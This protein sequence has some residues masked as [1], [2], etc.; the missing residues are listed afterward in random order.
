VKCKNCYGTGKKTGIK[1]NNNC[2]EMEVEFKCPECNGLGYIGEKEIDTWYTDKIVC[3]Y[4]G[5]EQDDFGDIFYK[6]ENTGKTMCGVCEK[7]FKVEV[8]YEPHYTTNKL[9]GEGDKDG[10]K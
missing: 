10:K 1:E 8:E 3:P 2:E 5:D 7:T 6:G 4:C 9:S